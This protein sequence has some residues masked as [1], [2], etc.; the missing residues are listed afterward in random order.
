MSI[1]EYDTTGAVTLGALTFDTECHQR[2]VE[3]HPR[4]DGRDARTR[5]V[6]GR[7]FTLN[8]NATNGGTLTAGTVAIAAGTNPTSIFSGSSQITTGADL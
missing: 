1:G 3:H 2:A 7:T 5:T 6:A 4:G 8:N